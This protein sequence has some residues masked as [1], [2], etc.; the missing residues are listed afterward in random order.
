MSDFQY[1]HLTSP[2]A[3]VIYRICIVFTSDKYGIHCAI[4]LERS[5]DITD[6][7]SR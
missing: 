6:W 4:Y 1:V 3:F 7:F 5:S 2:S